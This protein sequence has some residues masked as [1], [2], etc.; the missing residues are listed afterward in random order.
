MKWV[1]KRIYR[2]LAAV[3]AV[4]VL[5]QSTAFAEEG[6]EQGNTVNTTAVTLASPS[7]ILMEA[8]TGTVLFEKIQTDTKPCE[9]YQDYDAASYF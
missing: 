4:V 5:A 2:M 9:H 1:R 8:S 6:A 3:M 7:A